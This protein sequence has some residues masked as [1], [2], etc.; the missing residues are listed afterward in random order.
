ML[1]PAAYAIPSAFTYQNKWICLSKVFRKWT[2]SFDMDFQM[3][4][5]QYWH[6][7]SEIFN[8]ADQRL[9]TSLMEAVT[10]QWWLLPSEQ[11]PWLCLKKSC[12]YQKQ[13]LKKKNTILLLFIFCLHFSFVCIFI[14]ICRYHL[15][16]TAIKRGCNEELPQR[17][18][19]PGI[20]SLWELSL[21]VQSPIKWMCQFAIPWKYFI[22]L[23]IFLSIFILNIYSRKRWKCLEE[24]KNTKSSG[25]G[26]NLN[27]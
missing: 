7:R 12:N 6:W 4:T 19:L 21:T 2:N 3:T 13:S 9:E 23:I 22:V 16:I 18:F 8:E 1:R 24:K 5:T 25:G 14:N 20:M 27:T 11:S 17:K 26:N 15:N 10:L